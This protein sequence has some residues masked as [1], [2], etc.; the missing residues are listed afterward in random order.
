MHVYM[1]SCTAQEL[2]M[3]RQK[4]IMLCHANFNTSLYHG[5]LESSQFAC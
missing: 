4:N 5:Q 2:R 1:H 3:E